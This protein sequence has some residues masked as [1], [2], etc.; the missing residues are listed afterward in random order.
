MEGTKLGSFAELDW[1]LSPI[2]SPRGRGGDPVTM[3]C[4]AVDVR[5]FIV[6]VCNMGGRMKSVELEGWPRK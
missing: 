3:I 5:V 6:D 2:P 1:V 4:I